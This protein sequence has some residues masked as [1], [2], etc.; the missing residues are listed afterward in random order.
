MSSDEDKNLASSFIPTACTIGG[1]VLF[2]YGLYQ[3]LKLNSFQ[4]SKILTQD[5]KNESMLD[6]NSLKKEIEQSKNGR[7]FIKTDG[8][9]TTSK[10]IQHDKLPK[11][12]LL[13]LVKERFK[14]S[15]FTPAISTIISREYPDDISLD[16]SGRKSEGRNNVKIDI[17]DIMS[18]EREIKVIK[19]EIKGNKILSILFGTQQIDR[20]SL[21]YLRNKTRVY[22][23]GDAVLDGD[24][25]L[26]MHPL[27]SVLNP[28]GF[29]ISKKHHKIIEQELSTHSQSYM[30]AGTIIG[31]LGL[32]SMIALK[33]VSK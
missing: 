15:F 23:S 32:A 20:T 26:I 8:I 33:S 29:Y 4:N 17:D 13:A 10:P 27:P 5:V 28:K 3:R 14:S 24:D 30:I 9:L 21:E 16:I 22:I 7:V 31:G 19:E 6:Y 11:L 25:I 2:T 18:M 12:E 1:A